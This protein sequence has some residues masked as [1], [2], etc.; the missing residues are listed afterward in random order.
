MRLSLVKIG[1]SRG[2]R[3]PKSVIEQC[4]L[5]DEVELEVKKHQ[6]TIKAIHQTR[7]GWDQA[8]ATMA[9]VR[10]D[11]LLDADLATDWD[12]SEWTW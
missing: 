9:E 11:V 3:L 1:N 4:G 5:S 10:E 12:G 8:F 6:V 7:Q 2:V